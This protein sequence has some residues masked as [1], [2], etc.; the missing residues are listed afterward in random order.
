MPTTKDFYELLGLERGASADDVKKAYRKMALKY[1]PDRNPGDKEAEERFKEIAEAY[2]TLSDPGKRS[3][4]DQVGHEAFKSRGRPPS[5]GQGGYSDPMDIFSQAFGDSVGSIFDE[6]FGSTSTRRRRAGGPQPGADL[7]Y[8]LRIAFEE[9][10]FGAEKEVQVQKAETCDHC[11]GDG[12]EPGH[13]KRRCD[14]CGGTGQITMTQGFFSIR[15]PCPKC[16]G[17]G[18]IIERPCG[19][20]GGQ[21]RVARTKRIHLRI[22]AGVDTGSRLRISGEG[23][24]GVRGGPPGDLYVI[25]HVDNHELFQRQDDDILVEVPIDFVTAALGGDLE[26]PTISGAATL[27]IPPGTQTGTVFRLRGKGVPSLRGQGRGD[28]HVRVTVEVPQKL[29]RKQ[30]DKLREFAAGCDGDVHPKLAAYHEL[31]KR[32]FRK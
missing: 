9:A 32:L 18:E 24:A 5:G 31:L 2:E 14:Y 22:P 17:A 28:Q 8:D 4:Y 29:S 19:S 27:K 3:L 7:R 6:F 1:H 15:Q 10:I 23:E 25:L 12:A 26:V 13:G 11:K 20:C 16:R 30:Q 21:G